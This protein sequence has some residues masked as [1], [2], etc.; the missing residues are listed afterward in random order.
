MNHTVKVSILMVILSVLVLQVGA[1][2]KTGSSPVRVEF[3]LAEV[4]ESPG[5]TE[6][7]V[8]GT[9]EKIYLHKTVL[10]TNKDVTVAKV[11]EFDRVK[12]IQDQLE[13]LGVKVDTSA[14]GRYELALTFTD[15]AAERLAKATQGHLFKPLAVIIDGV[16]VTAPQLASSIS[17]NVRITG[18]FTK[19]KAEKIAAALNQK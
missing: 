1:M 18:G 16:I 9:N 7:T 15:E 3:R 17:K 13:A 2:Q 5:L 10:I 11:V 14:T 6:A 12:E 19:E 8:G 4:S